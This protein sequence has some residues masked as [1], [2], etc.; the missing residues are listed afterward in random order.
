MPL[1]EGLRGAGEG[2]DGGNAREDARLHGGKDLAVYPDG[3]AMAA[4]WQKELRVA[5]GSRPRE[6]V[7]EAVGSTG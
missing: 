4:D 3:L 5:M 2:D 7:E 1:L 6:E